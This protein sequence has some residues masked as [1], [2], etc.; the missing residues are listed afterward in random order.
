MFYAWVFFENRFKDFYLPDTEKWSKTIALRQSETGWDQD[1]FIPIRSLDRKCFVSCAS[2][3]RWLDV[4]PETTELP[5]Y[6]GCHYYMQNGTFKLGIM[7]TA[8]DRTDTAF[9]K[10]LLPKDQDITLGRD[11]R[12]VLQVAPDISVVSKQQ[13]SFRLRQDGICIYTDQSKNGSY[14]NG[15]PLNSTTTR[16]RFGDTVTL[17][18]GIKFIYLGTMLAINRMT[19]FESINMILAD[20]PVSTVTS[21]TR[22]CPSVL[23][24]HHRAPRF[25]QKPDNAEVRIDPPLE[26]QL[27]KQMP[28]WLTLGPST[29]MV[30]PMLMGSAISSSRGGF[31]GAGLAMVGTASALA[32]FWGLMNTSYRKKQAAETEELRVSRYAMYIAEAEQYLRSLNTQEYKRLLET[33][34][35]VEECALFPQSSSYR[36]WERMPKHSDFMSVRVGLGKVPLPNN[37]V[38]SDVKLSMIDDPLRDEPARLAD[39]YGT[40]P[41]APVTIDLRRETI[42]GV[43]GGDL[44]TSLGQG[45]LLQLAALHSY[46]D[47]RIA[48]ITDESAQS[49]WAWTRWLPHVFASED[50]QLRMVVSEPNAIQEVLTHLDEVLLMRSESA[51]NSDAEDGTDT[52]PLPHYVVFCTNPELLDNKPILRHML[53]KSWGMTLVLLAPSMEHLPKECRIV[54]DATSRSGA[55]Y[56]AE[57]DVSKVDFEYPNLALLQS[58]S[59]MLAPLRVKDSME[60]AAIPTMVS[61]LD[62]YNVRR[63]ENLD[64]WRFWNENHVYEGLRSTIGLRSGSQPFVLDISDKSHGPHGLI[65]GTTGSGKS[66][67]LQTYILSLALNYHPD[68]IRFIL[69]DYKGGGMADAFRRLPH[70]TGIIDNLQT[71]NTIA[72]ALASIQ[73]EIHR[74]EHLF[75][76]V[77]VNNID[78]YIR[79]FY[80][81]PAE[82][83]LPHLIIIVD[84]FAELKTDQPDFMRELVSAS[85]VGRSL[86]VHLILSTQKPSNSV[87]DEIWANSNFR[88]C[89]RVQSRSDSMEMLR[90]PD[91]AYLKNRGRCY[92]QVGNDEIYEQVQTSYSGLSYNPDEPSETE[93]PHLL[94]NAGRRI[95]IKRQKNTASDRE[96]TQMDA[97]LERIIRTAQE[98]GLP[99]NYRLWMEELSSIIFLR[100]IPGTAVAERKIWDGPN[101][102]EELRC[103]YAQ[104]DDVH[105]QRQFPVWMDLMANRNHMVVGMASTGKTTFVQTAV[106]S[107]ATR[108]SPAALHM[109]I[110]SLSSRTLNTLSALPHVGEI[111][112]NEE[113]DELLRLI[114]LLD[115]EN[116]R[117]RDLFAEASTD[118]FLAFNRSRP[119][120]PVPSIVV[121]MDRFAQVTEMLGDSESYTQKLY[122]L[123]REGSG[124]G[125]F[126][127][128]TAMKTNEIPYKIRDCFKGIGLQVNDRNDYIDIVGTRMPSDMPDI[129]Q[130]PGRGL[131]GVGENLYEIQIALAG[132]SASDVERADDIVR[133]CRSLNEQWTGPRPASIPRIPVEPTWQDFSSTAEYQTAQ[134][135]PWLFPLAYSKTSGTVV[136]IHL[137]SSFSFLITGPRQSGKTNLLRLLA[138]QWHQRNAKLCVVGDDSW[139][140]LCRRLG[141]ELYDLKSESWE[142]YVSWLNEEIKAR[143]LKR[144][145]AQAV[146]T[147]ELNRLARSFDPVVILIDDLDRFI[148]QNPAVANKLFAEVAS[149]AAKFGIYMYASISHQAY[150]P[151]RMQEPLVSLARQQR[152]IA[153]GGKLSDCDP[154]NVQMPYSKKNAALPLGEAYLFNNG[155]VSQIIL[156]KAPDPE[157]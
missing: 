40:I 60:S 96:I 120:D 44:A 123:I 11:S 23:I 155:D 48:V 105:S 16:L 85:R 122:N 106:M 156:P 119:N 154:W 157:V 19:A 70:V 147:A 129:A 52:I 62:I 47:V 89:L 88:I 46:H 12:C 67:M 143:N 110:L 35:S 13:G 113:T 69:I 131:A 15:L 41:N 144:K 149:R 30:L 71:G 3:F 138:E 78:D 6:N 53:T 108:Y 94:D 91:A 7:F 37:I 72:R 61:F 152:G 83:R 9:K 77:G 68:Q 117:R 153:L 33:C 39:T 93:L 43:L 84:E 103:I 80:D 148:T 92:V 79:F 10:F 22:R 34:P 65:A 121:F 128:A 66:V 115:Q 107:L 127:V 64:V 58:F 1:Y 20:P 56:T 104:G 101:T 28:L 74:R 112:Y 151:V 111:I 136:N 36:L 125:I 134:Q 116:L 32:V 49:R 137:D 145:A 38:T 118:S 97:V 21:D 8:C 99:D 2:K 73:G 63:I 102:G 50:R 75:R 109:Y 95:S 59:H 142:A 76:K 126:F 17:S 98:H 87:S 55:I 42:V 27:Q 24:Q 14:L 141:A 5:I 114:D 82:E 4:P 139:N 54:L 81:D 51:E 150:A 29:T 26:K 140:Q 45:V 57:G 18:A 132:S 100:S 31:M 133:L 146:S 90:R 135:D 130:F 86:G 25:L 124:R